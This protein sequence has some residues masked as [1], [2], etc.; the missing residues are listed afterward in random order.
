MMHPAPDPGE[1]SVVALWSS[2][3]RH[4]RLIGSVGLAGLLLGGVFGMLQPREYTS[5]ASFTVDDPR[6]ATPGSLSQLG[7]AGLLGGGSQSAQMYLDLLTSTVILGPVLDS[8]YTVADKGRSRR[9]VLGKLYGGD[10]KDSIKAR[11]KALDKL[12][13]QIKAE[14]RPSGV[15][16]VD[17]TTPDRAL[18]QQIASQIVGRLN[19]FNLERRQQHASTERE[20][21]AERLAATKADLRAAEEQLQLFL[22]ENRAYQSSPTLTIQEERLQRAVAFRQA[23]YTSVAQA[24]EQ[25]RMEEARN[26]P[27]ASILEA[28]DLPL[29]VAPRWGGLKAGSLGLVVGLI[30]GL[31]VGV[32]TDFFRRA[33]VAN[34]SDAE[35]LAH[36]REKERG[37]HAIA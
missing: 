20:F 15:V 28:P 1:T 25:A 6:S 35:A 22:Q 30:L 24:Y 9:V 26:T 34:P 14:L 10:I 31:L 2:L 11:A 12:T 27:T 8:T 7:L 36:L 16:S 32:F 3:L 5:H 18:S 37:S 21:N 23:L 4:R 13:G 29:R 19:V 33:I 17:V